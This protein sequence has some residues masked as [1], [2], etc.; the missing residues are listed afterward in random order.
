M[1]IILTERIS[2]R[3]L[4]AAGHILGNVLGVRYLV[5]DEL[6]A[7]QEG[8]IV[9][10]YGVKNAC[11]DFCM[12]ASD[13]IIREGVPDSAYYTEIIS[14][15]WPYFVGQKDEFDYEIDVFALCVFSLSR[16]EEYVIAEKDNYGRFPASQSVFFRDGILH[17]PHLDQSIH[18]F[19]ERLKKQFPAFTHRANV[20]KLM[21]T[22][23]VDHAW[24]YKNKG[25]VRNLAGAALNV[26]KGN[27]KTL[28]ERIKVLTGVLADPYNSFGE[29]RNAFH[30]SDVRYF[31]L[32]GD[33]NKI[34]I[35]IHH[36][37]SA[38]R[39]LIRRLSDEYP[40]G[41]HP[42]SRTADRPGQ[43]REEI[44]RLEDITGMKVTTSRQHFLQMKLPDTYRALTDAGIAS[45]YTMGYADAAGFRAGT[46][47]P[48]RWFDLVRNEETQLVVYPF[49]AMDVTLRDYL[50]L[51]EDEAFA[52]IEKMW[53]EVEKYGG[54]F[55]LLWHNSSFIDSEG[56]SGWKSRLI[57]FIGE[58]KQ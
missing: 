9:L 25:F 33:Y 26:F 44:H 17:Q 22:I 51:S 43:L 12:Y 53:S 39:D 19:A 10:A 55:I 31:I 7:K 15:P 1:I 20:A 50:S 29:I 14:R 4:Y 48:F 49:V 30:P 18:A 41:V 8:D 24:K 37:C 57:K 35:N 11:A 36:R 56:W 47:Y 45:D 23:D 27:F 3:L 5:C 16:C 58:N 34:D 52:L 28:A 42:S 21:L 32:L 6:P 46:A 38:F 40:V 2:P 13:F 54:N